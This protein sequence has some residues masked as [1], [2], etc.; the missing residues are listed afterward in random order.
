MCSGSWEKTLIRAGWSEEVRILVLTCKSLLFRF[1]AKNQA[2]SSL[3]FLL[4]MVQ[5]GKYASTLAL[6]PHV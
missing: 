4:W 3:D 6:S 1:Q 2:H 5:A